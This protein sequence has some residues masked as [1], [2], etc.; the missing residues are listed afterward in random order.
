M[1]G[2]NEAN[3][4]QMD[5]IEC[6]LSEGDES[7]TQ[8]AHHVLTF[9]TQYYVQSRPTD[10]KRQTHP[11]RIPAPLAVPLVA[12]SRKLGIA[13]IVTYADTVLWNWTLIDP[14]Q[15][16]SCHNVRIIDLF[17]GDEQEEHFFLTSLRIEISGKP[18]LRLMS[19]FAASGADGDR[20]LTRLAED[21][22]VL[23]QNIREVTRIFRN[24]RGGLDPGFFYNIFRPVRKCSLSGLRTTALL[25]TRDAD[26]AK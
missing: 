15:P 7:I 9:L 5:I 10:L 18:S 20:P 12:V 11:I 8:R 24:V 19:Q 23:A 6:D 17:T 4:S 25:T 26:H 16:L 22:E 14:D 13:P 21:L 2:N 3:G 1:R